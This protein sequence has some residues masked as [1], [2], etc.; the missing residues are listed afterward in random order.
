MFA[1]IAIAFLISLGI[2][3]VLFFVAKGLYS[4]FSPQILHILVAVLVI[5]GSTVAGTVAVTSQK[6]LGYVASLEAG[7]QNIT[8]QMDDL[9]AQY[10]LDRYGIS[11]TEIAG[12]Y[13]GGAAAIAKSKLGRARTLSIVVMVVLN[14]LLGLFLVNAG[15]KVRGRKS[16]YSGS[17]DMEDLDDLGT[18]S[19]LDDLDLD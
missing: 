7:A 6:A 3:L 1:N 14:I 5:S 16:Y 12:G 10:G 4:R 18:S 8:G 17:D 11:A 13:V 2:A 9:Q 19:S 15:S